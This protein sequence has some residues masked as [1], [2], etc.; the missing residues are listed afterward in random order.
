MLPL[1]QRQCA[2]W[3][4]EGDQQQEVKSDLR[5][6]TSGRGDSDDEATDEL[7]PE[8]SVSNLLEMSDYRLPRFSSELLVERYT[9]LRRRRNAFCADN[10]LGGCSAQQHARGGPLGDNHVT[11]T[12]LRKSTGLNVSHPSST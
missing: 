7:P 6:S 2:A 11:A 5:D 9:V 8:A 10:G 3:R 1:P 4:D 12:R